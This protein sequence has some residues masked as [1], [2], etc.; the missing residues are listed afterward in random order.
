MSENSEKLFLLDGMALV[1]RAY[2]AMIRN[3]RVTSGGLNTSAVFGY[4]NTLL[5]IVQN[6]NPSHLAV[7]FDTPEPTHR[8]EEYTEYKAHREA[9]PE[10]L[11]TALPY[12][13]KMTE[14]FSI[15]CIRCPGFEAD[16]VIGTLA[17][18][19]G[20]TGVET[21]M[22]TPDKDYAQ[23]VSDTV[24]IYK[25][26]RMGG[27]PEVLGVAEILEQWGVERVEQVIDVLALMGDSSDNVPGIPG[28]G[29][30]TAKKLVAQFA[31]VENLI[32][33]TDQLKG[34]QKENV[35]QYADQ[36][37]MAK[38]LVTIVC[39]V[40]LACTI[41]DLERRDPDQKRLKALFSELEFRTLGN[42]FFGDS[43]TIAPLGAEGP[44]DTPETT[45]A[46][47]SD[48]AAVD[49]ST[50]KTIENTRHDYKLVD[51]PEA[52]A[53]LIAD[54]KKQ[55]S[56]CIDLETTSLDPK[57]AEIVGL[58]CSYAAHTGFYVPFPEDSTAS[59]AVLGEFTEL[60]EDPGIEIVGHNLKFDLGVLKWHG[61]NAGARIF[62][63]LLAHFLA[64]P[65][66]RHKMDYLAEVYLGYAPVGIDALIGD[67]KSGQISM[68]DVPVEQAAEYAAED[69]DI[70]WQLRG[71]LEPMLK[72]K[73]A[74]RVFYKIETPLI[75]VLIAM[76]AEGIALDKAALVSYSKELS[77]E[78]CTLEKKIYHAAGENFNIDSPKQLGVILF[79]V[80]K[81]E[82]NPKKTKTGQYATNEQVLTQLANRHEIIREVLDFRNARKLK[83]VYVDQLPGA[84]F[85]KTDRVHTNYNQAVTVTGRLQSAG[86]NLQNIPIR[87]ERGREIRKAFLHRNGDFEI[88]SADY[89]QI[90]LRIIAELSQDPGLLNAFFEGLDIHSATAAS[91]YG[92]PIDSVTDN[93]RRRAKMVN[94]G[95]AYGISAFGLGQRLGISRVEAKNLIDQYFDKYP[96]VQDYIENTIEFARR[97]GFVE[98]VMGRR[99][100]LRDINSQNAT[101]RGAAE[102]N[103]INMPIQGTAADMIKLAMINI[104]REL[105]ADG[106]RTKMLLQVHDELVFDLHRD[107]AEKVCPLVESNMKDAI[108]M[109]VP[110]VVEMGTG[111]N[112]LEAH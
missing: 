9:I 51:G 37:L 25:P 31:S 23:L 93:M 49:T 112:W 19:A 92:V 72:E 69:A 32:A 86:P 43:F 64:E 82:D 95:I 8:H 57:V 66:M 21:Y 18:A 16:D 79:D 48:G 50:L 6:Q 30:K 60:L 35:E 36:G 27:S 90:E 103:A 106:F 17:K 105:S 11:A 107:E 62:D 61:V 83:S 10:D 80:L 94:F 24:F 34:K 41:D 99:R 101:A 55:K 68:R 29:E 33:N 63:T 65:E 109:K 74:E 91:V 7:V 96:G 28:I 54:L 40:P 100:Y 59:R 88:L 111:P 2:F 14:A 53:V 44:G 26:G 87:T 81:L 46:V 75:E 77:E 89:S 1:Y 98:T 84:V 85:G 5:D 73:N 67:K 42:R 110:I 78:I 12:I 3:P 13:D 4:I 38:R 20:Q 76:E 71:V 58:A 56:F 104:Y 97:N 70:T 15:P 108:P 52:R 22:V 102:R 39:D 47:A 45:A